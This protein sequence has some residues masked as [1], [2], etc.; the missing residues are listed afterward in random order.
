M[1]DEHDARRV[2]LA[3]DGRDSA[4]GGGLP[5]PDAFRAAEQHLLDHG[6][7]PLADV[8]KTVTEAMIIKERRIL[9]LWGSWEAF[10]RDILDQLA[11]KKLV[12]RTDSFTEADLW[13]LTANFKPGVRHTVMDNPRIRLS[14]TTERIRTRENAIGRVVLELNTLSA[15]LRN[16]GFLDPESGEAFLSLIQLLERPPE[17]PPKRT[18]GGVKVKHFSEEPEDSPH[19]QQ[20][21]T[22]CKNPYPLTREHWYC[23]W[24][25]RGYYWR[26]ICK[27]CMSKQK[28]AHEKEKEKE[29]QQ[30]ILDLDAEGLPVT[31]DLVCRRIGTQDRRR[32]I[33]HW[34]RLYRERGVDIKCPE[35]YR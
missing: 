29:V 20:A 19:L 25:R 16:Q 10:T 26:T 15:G 35:A 21:C 18:G 4:S 17:P 22:K 3:G 9:S 5:L 30:A 12:Q 23:D 7:S 2:R 33:A 32:T 14:V 1:R 34:N 11:Y 24:S 31:V 27:T 13:E 6:V 28:I 8:T